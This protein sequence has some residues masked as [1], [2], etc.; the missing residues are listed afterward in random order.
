MNL[1][2]P[3]TRPAWRTWLAA[4]HAGET[5]IWLVYSKRHTHQPRVEYA[6]A[7]EEALCFGWI[8]SIVRTI[9]ADRYAQKFTPRKAKSKWSALNLE[10]FA[11][12]V[13][14]GK[15]TSAGL[16][17]APPEEEA[18]AAVP[19]IPKA[20]VGEGEEAVPSY[21][22]EALRANGVA[23]TNFSRFAP[24]YR[25]LYIRWIEA[26]KREETRRKRLAEAVSLLERN[27]KLGLK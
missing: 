11:R 3:T 10:R 27:Q 20:P 19:A 26:A 21:I 14:E 16:A 7:V 22:E 15:M 23:W 25:R 13:R 24:S 9:D 12:M 5:E 2:H 4:N 17:K 8:D 18:A 6:E 1:L